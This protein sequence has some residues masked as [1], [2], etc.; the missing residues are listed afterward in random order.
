M[1]TET[2]QWNN[3]RGVMVR[4]TVLISSPTKAEKINPAQLELPVQICAGMRPEQHTQPC[5][6]QGQRREGPTLYLQHIF[7]SLVDEL[8]VHRVEQGVSREDL[9]PGKGS[10]KQNSSSTS[11]QMATKGL[12]SFRDAC[13]ALGNTG[14]EMG[15]GFYRVSS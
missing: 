15:G 9:A 3:M 12:Q 11:H 8:H 10:T 13:K 7:P 2:L 14:R 6:A 4:D 5:P 1:F